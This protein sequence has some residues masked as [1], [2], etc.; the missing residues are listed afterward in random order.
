MQNIIAIIGL[1]YVGLPLAI[2]FA[3]KYKVF[4]YDID[5]SRIKD[6]FKFNDKTTETNISDL[7]SL[8]KKEI[9]DLNDHGLYL[10]ST[11]NEIAIA[12]RYIITVPTPINKNLEPDLSYLI[13]ASKSISSI[14]KKGDF[15]IYES[16]VFPGCTEEE[17]V[18]IL[19]SESG[20]KYNR[21]FF[22][23][24]SPERVSPGVSSIKLTNIKKV[25]SGSNEDVAKE[26]DFLYSSI[27]EA[28][29]HLAPSIKVAEAS[30]SIENAQRDL[31]ISFVNELALIFD[32]MGIDTQDVLEA[33]KTKWNFIPFSPGLV[34]GHCISVDPY[35]LVYK[36]KKLGYKP[37][38][39]LSGREVNNSM[40]L[41]IASKVC[42]LLL[43]KNIVIS[44]SRVLILG[45]TFKENCPDIR[46]TQVIDIY[47]TLTQLA[48]KVDVYDPVANKLEVKAKLNINLVE[49]Y[50][51]KYTL[52]I[53]AVS[54]KEFK[55][56]NFKKLKKEGAIIYDVKSFIKKEYIDARL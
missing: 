43:N 56:I 25:T 15:V 19:E 48:L 42:D 8:I 14:L 27:I 21:D 17:C 29:T 26:I 3:K 37:S 33:A 38:V 1:G 20:L 7:K 39:I 46:N 22:C 52:I 45:V 13:S 47:N 49:N 9:S 51:D 31:N 23:G 18:P 28:G 4:G 2:E 6:L 24:Y 41:F 30:K 34:G 50:N 40:G 36:S 55:L 5:K 35:Y 12:N 53:L 16:T 54:H 11:L 10:T 44:K 32:K